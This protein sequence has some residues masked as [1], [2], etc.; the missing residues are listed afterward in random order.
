MLDIGFAVDFCFFLLFV[1]FVLIIQS[2]LAMAVVTDEVQLKIRASFLELLEFGQFLRSDERPINGIDGLTWQLVIYPNGEKNENFGYFQAYVILSK[3]GFETSVEICIKDSDL[4]HQF[5]VVQADA[6]RIRHPMIIFNGDI[7]SSGCIKDEEFLVEAK[8]EIKKPLQ[9][10]NPIGNEA[11]V[12]R[13]FEDSF[14]LTLDPEMLCLNETGVPMIMDSQRNN[15]ITWNVVYF[16]NGEYPDETD[17]VKVRIIISG[18]PA[19]ITWTAGLAIGSSTIY[20][21]DTIELTGED[22]TGA[23]VATHYQCKIANKVAGNIEIVVNV[24]FSKDANYITYR[25]KGQHAVSDAIHMEFPSGLFDL[26][27]NGQFESS[28]NK[29]L[30]TPNCTCSQKNAKHT[31]RIRYFFA[32]EDE[33]DKGHLTLYIDVDNPK[34]EP[35][36]VKGTITIDGMV[37][38]QPYTFEFQQQKSQSFLIKRLVSINDMRVKG[39]LEGMD[40]GINCDA[41]FETH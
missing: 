3:G 36:S 2:D 9:M 7:H 8:I 38:A 6:G 26:D 16:P 40:V 4:K 24:K 20:T 17:H 22:G 1:A 13:T 19:I 10:P 5:K 29:L 32:G 37:D 27:Y 31:W 35:I 25:D 30:P 12:I 15:G 18:G 28:D 14:T 21:G 11:P 41:T 23:C 33:E 34:L 39:A